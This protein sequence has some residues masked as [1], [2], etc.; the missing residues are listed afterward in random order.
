[1]CYESCLERNCETILT[2]GFKSHNEEDRKQLG[3][4][5]HLTKRREIKGNLHLGEK[6][7]ESVIGN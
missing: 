7:E 2:K 3:H 1:M 6:S 5:N 4:L